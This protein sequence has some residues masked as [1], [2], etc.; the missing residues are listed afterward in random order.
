MNTDRHN[1]LSLKVLLFCFFGGEYTL[2]YIVNGH[3]IVL[4]D[5]L[6]KETG[7]NLS[8]PEMQIK[9]IICRDEFG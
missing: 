3:V 7:W 8:T 9:I 2:M 6:Q 1:L 4:F 5:I